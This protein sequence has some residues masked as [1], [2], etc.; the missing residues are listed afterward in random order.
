MEDI[1]GKY[2]HSSMHNRCQPAK[3]APGVVNPVYWPGSWCWY[4]IMLIR[5]ENNVACSASC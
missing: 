3:Q 1:R 5:V 2:T 4:M